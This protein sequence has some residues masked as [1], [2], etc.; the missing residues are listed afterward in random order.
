MIKWYADAR[1][2]SLSPCL[3]EDPFGM[4][5]ASDLVFLREFGC[6]KLLHAED[7][8]GGEGAAL[9]YVQANHADVA[10]HLGSSQLELFRR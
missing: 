7:V 4:I 10:R 1:G 8:A 3:D 2:T 5:T 6:E 9:G